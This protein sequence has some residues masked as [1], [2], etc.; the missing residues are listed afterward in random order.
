MPT[1]THSDAPDFWVCI[2]ARRGS[3]RLPDKPLADLCGWPMVLWVASAGLQSAASRV[4]V[5][6]DDHE[7]Y[8]TVARA[9]HDPE[10]SLPPCRSA[11]PA[12]QTTHRQRSVEVLLTDPNHPT[13]TDRLAEVVRQTRAPEQQ[14]IVNLQGDEP[15]MPP[16]LLNQVAQRLAQDTGAAV[17]TAACPIRDS[18]EV[19][20]P[21][22]VKVVCDQ[23]GRALY[24]SRAPIPFW[25]DG[26]SGQAGLEQDRQP[27]GS[28]LRHLGL[29]AYRAGPLLAYSRW[30]PSPLE[31]LEKLEQLR[32][33]HYGQAITVQ[34]LAEPPPAGVDT[35][36]DLAEMRRVLSLGP[37][38]RL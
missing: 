6:T 3:T 7:I 17:A 28:Y 23:H 24:F 29:Y 27:P 2:P 32:W 20:S 18:Q 12:A 21:H 5:A 16:E 11:E 36:E 19:F 38:A 37:Q 25:R 8:D 33:L 15:L 35:P 34:W 13:G 30:A 26:W 14:I 9:I 4:I 1:Q 10:R 22:V 31:E